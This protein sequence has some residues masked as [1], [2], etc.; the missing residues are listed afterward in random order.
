LNRIPVHG[1]PAERGRQYGQL[2]APLVHRAIASYRE[3]FHRRVGLE[4]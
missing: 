4:L 2:A 3:V 1:A